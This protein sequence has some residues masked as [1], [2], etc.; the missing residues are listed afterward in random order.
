MQCTSLPMELTGPGDFTFPNPV[1][2]QTHHY[3]QCSSLSHTDP[4]KATSLDIMAENSDDHQTTVKVKPTHWRNRRKV[5]APSALRAVSQD[6]ILCQ[7]R[8]HHPILKPHTETPFFSF[9]FFQ[10]F[11]GL[12]VLRGPIPALRV[13]ASCVGTADTE[14]CCKPT[15]SETR[16]SHGDGWDHAPFSYRSFSQ[17]GTEKRGCQHMCQDQSR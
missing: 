8:K 17:K 15:I 6:T 16:K 9:F 3:C 4:L 1:S 2:A 11:I 5:V 12:L 7:Y 14:V 13:S 10:A